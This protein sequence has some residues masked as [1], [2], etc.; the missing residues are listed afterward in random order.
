MGGSALKGRDRNLACSKAQVKD[1]DI[2]YK[3][4]DPLGFV[5]RNNLIRSHLHAS[6][7]AKVGGR[8]ANLENGQHA[9]PIGEALVKQA[10]A[11]NMLN[12]GKRSVERP[13]SVLD[14][15]TPKLIAAVDLGTTP[16]FTIKDE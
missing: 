1:R 6:Q 10:Q 12:V 15:A 8:L 13:R 4:D 9:S 3:G 7:R 11:A 16:G 2:E 5:I 14:H